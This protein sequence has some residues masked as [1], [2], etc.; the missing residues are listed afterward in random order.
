MTS[1]MYPT[2]E[3]LTVCDSN[4]FCLTASRTLC[5]CSPLVLPAS[6]VTRSVREQPGSSVVVTPPPSMEKCLC[7]IISARST[8]GR[9]PLFRSTMGL[10]ILR[11]RSILGNLTKGK[12]SSSAIVEGSSTV[13]WGKVPSPRTS[14]V[15]CF[16]FGS[17]PSRTTASKVATY[18]EMA[19]GSK[20]SVTYLC[21][22]G[23]TS[24]DAGCTS[25][26]NFSPPASSLGARVKS[27]E[28]GTFLGLEIRKLA[29]TPPV[30]ST[31][32]GS[33]F[34]SSSGS[35][36]VASPSSSPARLASTGPKENTL[37]VVSNAFVSSMDGSR[38]TTSLCSSNIPRKSSAAM[39]GMTLSPATG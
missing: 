2:A 27:T 3:N 35:A 28:H 11:P 26:G 33:P 32:F 20:Y 5:A 15:N 7:V 10:V 25:M 9:M 16:V 37:F 23:G 21:S 18:E 24:R 34:S 17:A 36:G 19:L 31:G 8:A 39:P 30:G 12:P 14:Q 4:A 13:T 6:K 22:C 1:S 38:A 29:L